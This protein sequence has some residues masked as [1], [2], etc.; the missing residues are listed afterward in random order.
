MTQFENLLSFVI[1]VLVMS[2]I[3]GAS[4]LYVLSQGLIRDWKRSFSTVRDYKIAFLK[5]F[6]T[7]ISNPKALV[8]YLSFLPQFVVPGKPFSIQIFTLGMVNIVILIFVLIIYSV[9]AIKVSKVIQGSNVKKIINRIIGVTLMSFGV[10]L[11][12]YQD[13]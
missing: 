5:G 1:L 6:L 12:R 7:S 13:T 4:V 11:F 2:C 8:F 3:P 9:L 10:S